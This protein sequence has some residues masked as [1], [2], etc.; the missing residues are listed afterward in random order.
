MDLSTRSLDYA[1]NIIPKVNPLREIR[2]IVEEYH[3]KL[4]LQKVLQ[5]KC[6]YTTLFVKRSIRNYKSYQM[7]SFLKRIGKFPNAE[8]RRLFLYA[9]FDTCKHEKTCPKCSSSQYD[10]VGHVLNSCE[11]SMQP[12]LSMRL[13]FIFYGVPTSFDFANKEAIFSLVLDCRLTYLKILCS[14]LTDIGTYS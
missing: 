3:F 13:K 14:F 4:D 9:L 6:L 8:G 1:S 2:K 12:R 5:T 7:E 11:K 10:V